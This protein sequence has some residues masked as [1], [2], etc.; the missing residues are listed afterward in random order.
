MPRNQP[1]SAFNP[2]RFLQKFAVS[3][4]VVCTFAVYAVHEHLANSDGTIDAATPT[5][6]SVTQQL[7][8]ALQPIPTAPP[9]ASSAPQAAPPRAAQVKPQA[10]PTAAAIAK[11][12]YRDGTYTGPNIDAFYGYVQVKATVRNGKLSDVQFVKFPND[13]RTSV[14]INAVAVPYLQSEAIKAQSANV[15]FISGATLT[16]EAFAQSLQTALNSAKN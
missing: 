14:R 7:P 13:R 1:A 16:S 8:D 10:V 6:S 9:L 15:D 12:Q 11:G 4:F 2:I 3:A 5:P